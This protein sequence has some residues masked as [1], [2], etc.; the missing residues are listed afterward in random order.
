MAMHRTFNPSSAVQV[1]N[2]SIKGSS[3]KNKPLTNFYEEIKSFCDPENDIESI[4]IILNYYRDDEYE[5]NLDVN[6]FLE[7]AKRI[8]YNSGYGDNVIN[9]T[10]KI[11]LKNG[12]WLE[13]S[14]GEGTPENF[15]L[16]SKRI[17]K[18]EK[19]DDIAIILNKKHRCPHKET[20]IDKQNIKLRSPS[21]S[22][23]IWFEKEGKIITEEHNYVNHHYK[24]E[25]WKLLKTYQRAK[26]EEQ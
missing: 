13:R 22:Y 6:W 17:F 1:R 4:S 20:L 10:I 19:I 23:A 11:N 5:T 12:K 3:M 26:E 14:T 9:E 25:H 8:D 24:E 18:E 7:Q 16:M 15:V 21:G 2:G